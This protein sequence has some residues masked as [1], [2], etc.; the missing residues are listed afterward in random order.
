[1][2]Q[3]KLMKEGGDGARG[4]QLHGAD[5]Y[6]IGRTRPDFGGKVRA[7]NIVET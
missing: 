5:A 7:A 1:M 3:A 4:M 6:S 2:W